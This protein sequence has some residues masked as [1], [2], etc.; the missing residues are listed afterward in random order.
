ME[1]LTLETAKRMIAASVRYARDICGFSCSIAVV[2]KSGAVLAVYRMDDAGA[3]TTDIAIQKAWTAVSMKLPTLMMAR[4]I[5]PRRTGL[6]L[7]DHGLGIA[8]Q[9]KNR[10]ASIAGGI[11]VMNDSSEII[12]AL[13]CSGVPAGLGRISDTAVVQ[14]GLSSGY[15]GVAA[16][17]LAPLG[18]QDHNT[19]TLHLATQIADAALKR[20]QRVGVKCAVAVADDNGWTTVVQRMEGALIPTS[21]M[22]RDKAWTAAAFRMATAEVAKFGDPSR[23]DYGFNTANWNDRLTTI[24]GGL[25]VLKG[26][27]LIGAIGVAGG[28]LKQDVAICRYATRRELGPAQTA[29]TRLPGNIPGGSSSLSC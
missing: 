29:M 23:P 6:M 21:D 26:G 8:N 11:L 3:A 2:D 22:A 24:P 16:T 5:D 25:P 27:R 19:L 12:G 18:A 9:A 4:M 1:E 17:S 15:D 13:G 14:A 10:F 20:A 28:T 7:G